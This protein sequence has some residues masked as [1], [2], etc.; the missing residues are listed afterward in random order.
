MRVKFN[1]LSRLE[2]QNI[3]K[4]KQLQSMSDSR[5][6]TRNIGSDF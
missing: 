6:A 3:L 4:S 5:A 2:I 1:L